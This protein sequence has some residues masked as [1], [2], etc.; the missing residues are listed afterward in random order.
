MQI[1]NYFI[2]KYLGGI[3]D[4]ELLI[5]G[6]PSGFGK[7]TFANSL[8]FDMLE[9]GIRPALFSLENTIGDTLKLKAFL[10]WKNKTRN[11]NLKFRDWKMLSEKD[12][13]VADS[14]ISAYNLINTFMLVENEGVYGLEKLT[15]DLERAKQ[16]GANLIILDH[17]DFIDDGG[18][19]LP[20]AQTKMMQTIK[21]FVDNN[22]IPVIAFSQLKKIMDKKVIIPTESDVAG[23]ANKF[24]F[25]TGIIMI[26][27]DSENQYPEEHRYATY[28]VVRKDRYGSG[29]NVGERIFFDAKL[30]T[31]EKF[32]F[33]VGVSVD[34]TKIKE[35]GI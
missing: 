10:I 4:N 26:Q 7:T 21:D 22:K 15:A 23:S 34:G 31:Y 33:K 13:D 12:Q 2:D 20:L 3:T 18:L 6:C 16:S 28:F 17:L 11:W 29:V 9:I 30:G 27:R 8:A 32:G 24:R 1:N 25:S 14:Y 19:S 35:L 5:I